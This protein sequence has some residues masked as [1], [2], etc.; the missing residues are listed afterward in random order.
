MSLTF[1]FFFLLIKVKLLDWPSHSPD[2][3]PME[4]IW[5]L[6]KRNIAK[7][8]AQNIDDLVEAIHF[9]CTNF[10][11]SVISNIFL[12]IYKRINLLIKSNGNTLAY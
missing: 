12:S 9:E 1:E 7:K 8:D 6:L 2:V 11:S 3:N 4:N 10:S 5:A